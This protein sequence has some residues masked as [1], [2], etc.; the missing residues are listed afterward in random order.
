MIAPIA[1][2]GLDGDASRWVNTVNDRI[3]QLVSETNTSSLKITL[4]EMVERWR[5]EA[6]DLQEKSI[7][8]IIKG[9]YRIK[10]DI[11]AFMSHG[12]TKCSD[13]L[14]EVLEKQNETPE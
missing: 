6:V 13:E 5:K 3:N 7:K 9:E 12:L 4:Y 11:C 8:H 10:A 1:N 2:R 14:S